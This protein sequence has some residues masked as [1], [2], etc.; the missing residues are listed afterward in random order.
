MIEF[1]HLPSSPSQMLSVQDAYNEIYRSKGIQHR[2]A[3]YSWLI[4]LL[5]PQP[6]RTLM[7]ISCGEGRLVNLARQLGLVASGTD[8]AI[9]GVQKGRSEDPQA[10]WFVAD[11][12]MLPVASATQDYITHIGSLEHY[13]IPLAGA[14]E[15]ARILKPEGRACVLLPNAFGLTG[16]IRHVIRTGDVFDDG[17][18]LQR[19][20]TR[21]YW[22][23]LLISSGLEIEKVATY[24][25]SM[26]IAPRN[27]ADWLWFFSHPLKL[28]R[29]LFA[30]FIPTNLS[31]HFVFICRPAKIKF[32]R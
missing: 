25:G 18:P 22:E 26:I 10:G 6:G 23:N 29:L 12:E 27:F 17:Q 7:D 16:N 13:Q 1:R 32:T 9:D 28:V 24:E 15:I 8:F 2:D 19:Y 20:A 30:R 11:G 21:R 5:D 14:R 31:N 3:V 4:R